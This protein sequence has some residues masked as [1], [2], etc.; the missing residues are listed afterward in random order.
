V[1]TYAVYIERDDRGSRIKRTEPIEEYKARINKLLKGNVLQA[2]RLIGRMMDR[3]M[4]EL[5]KARPNAAIIGNARAGAVATLQGTGVFQEY[6]TVSHLALDADEIAGILDRAEAL[7][8]QLAPYSAPNNPQLAVE[9]ASSA[10]IPEPVDATG[11]PMAAPPPLTQPQASIIQPEPSGASTIASQRG[12]EGA[13]AAA[14]SP[15]TTP[16]L[17]FAQNSDLP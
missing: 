1:G 12:G 17:D 10:A 13:E 6:T 5:D 8:A 9:Q 2:V 16:H 14:G 4:L 11:E 3:A 7:R 15:N